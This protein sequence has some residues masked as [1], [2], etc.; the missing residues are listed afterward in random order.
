MTP[1]TI[2]PETAAL[3]CRELEA[4]G[5]QVDVDVDTIHLYETGTV[6]VRVEVHALWA[7]CRIAPGGVYWHPRRQT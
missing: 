4:D 3:L 7:A 2:R 5:I 6:P 1:L